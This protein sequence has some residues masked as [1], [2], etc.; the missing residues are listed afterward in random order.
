MDSL[1]FLVSVLAAGFR[2]MAA[3]AASYDVREAYGRLISL[4]RERGGGNRLSLLKRMSIKGEALNPGRNSRWPRET[5]PLVELADDSDVREAAG[6]LLYALAKVSVDVIASAQVAKYS[7]HGHKFARA[8]R[9]LSL[10]VGD[11]QGEEPAP[12]RRGGFGGTGTE[13]S[14]AVGT[15]VL[16][17]ADRDDGEPLSIEIGKTDFFAYRIDENLTYAGPL[18]ALPYYPG[19]DTDGSGVDS[20]A[21]SGDDSG[22]RPE[23]P[24]EEPA[25]QNPRVI[26]ANLLVERFVPGGSA[27]LTVVLRLPDKPARGKWQG[28]ATLGAADDP[29]RIEVVAQGFTLVSEPPAPFLIPADR[30]SAPVA[31]ELNIEEA[32]QRWLHILVIQN[33]RLCGELVINDFSSLGQGPVQQGARS[34]VRNIY[35]ADLTMVVRS[36]DGRIEVSSPRERA[37]LDHVPMTGFKYPEAPFRA[38]LADRLRSLYDGSADPDWAAHELQLVGAELAKCLPPDCVRLLRRADIRTVMLRHEDDFDFPFELCYLDDA[39]DPFFVGDR[40][41]I[42]RWY[43]G[44]NNP[45]D[46][47]TKRVGK[48]AF[49]TGGVEASDIDREFLEKHYPGRMIVFDKHADVVEK[50]FKTADFDLIHFTGHCRQKDQSL[51]G[52]ELAD[53]TFLRAIDIGQLERERIFAAAQPFVFLN[54]CSSAQP[55]LGLVQRGSFVHRFVTS[56]ASAVVGTLWPV[57]GAV[58]NEFAQHFYGELA[59]KPIGEALLAA[60]AAL[61]DDGAAIEPA[62]SITRLARQVAVRSYC[63]FANPDLRLVE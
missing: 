5:R 17:V 55:Y 26:D 29:M 12:L 28:G 9:Q 59:R 45:P 56:R 50:L 34:T 2:V 3:G 53:G 61:V 21:V 18:P 15:V 11:D 31:F 13:L 62:S 20:G 48:V 36:G 35:E 33:G 1:S 14:S 38:L 58:A 54:A 6:F 24:A 52:L 60:K 32:G 7:I 25:P 43:L 63:L 27:T 10:S 23:S 19:G 57:A 39:D 42:C 46:V 51:A 30:D 16:P 8:W 37:C 47:V 40:I 22:D 49:L 44:V 41:A 4:I